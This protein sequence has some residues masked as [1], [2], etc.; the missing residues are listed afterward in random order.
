MKRIRRLGR[1]KSLRA[2]TLVLV[3]ASCIVLAAIGLY[4]LSAGRGTREERVYRIGWENDPPF[5]VALP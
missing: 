3:A 5:Q 1:M 4:R 2:K